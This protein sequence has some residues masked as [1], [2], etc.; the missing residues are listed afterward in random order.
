[1]L[2]MRISVIAKT[3]G[4]LNCRRFW[5]HKMEK[6]WSESLWN[7]EFKHNVI[8]YMTTVLCHDVCDPVFLGNTT[9]IQQDNMSHVTKLKSS[10]ASFLNIQCQQI[11]HVSMDQYLWGRVC[12]SCGTE[13]YVTPR[14][15]IRVILMHS[16]GYLISCYALLIDIFTY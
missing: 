9:C 1:M 5:F 16:D 14:F 6:Q 10:Q 7:F 15:N 4:I 13:V 8:L 11:C 3:W 2:W 12:S